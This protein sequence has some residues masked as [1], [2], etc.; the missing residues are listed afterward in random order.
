MAR[1][2]E[3]VEIKRP[4]DKVFVYTTEAKSWPRWHGTMPEAEQTS[5]GQVSV[6]TTF[7]GKNHM[8]GCRSKV[9]IGVDWLRQ[10]WFEDDGYR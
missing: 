6:G 2:E 7:R 10:S 3:S 4:V 8:M 1:I 9:Q 5:Q